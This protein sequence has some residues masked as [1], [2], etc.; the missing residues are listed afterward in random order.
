MSTRALYTFVGGKN[1]P[2][3]NVYVHADG[4]PSGAADYLNKTLLYAWPLPR[5]DHDE[6]AAAFVA[7]TKV[8]H[9]GRPMP[10]GTR[11]L[12]SN[13]DWSEH[14]PGDIQFRYEISH[15]RKDLIVEA[16][17]VNFKPNGKDAGNPLFKGSLAKF[18]AWAKSK[19]NTA[20]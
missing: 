7:A 5:F 13:D 12:P 19:E 15:D 14:A 6:F 2:K 9:N 3:L 11:L 20:G 4:Y 10:G 17:T 18:E 8:D 1:E 16:F